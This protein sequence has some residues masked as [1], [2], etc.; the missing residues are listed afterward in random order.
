MNKVKRNIYIVL[1]IIAIILFIR[2]KT[3][4]EEIVDSTSISSTSSTSKDNENFKKETE[5]IEEDPYAYL[6]AKRTELKAGKYKVGRDGDINSGT[7]NITAKK[8]YGLLTG[9]LSWEGFI[10]ETIGYSNFTKITETYEGLF[11]LPGDEFTIEGDCVL[12]FEPA[13]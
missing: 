10:S 13:E 2:I 5:I 1:I 3:E 9:D 11:L 6:R 8:G 4:A 7:Y 12:I